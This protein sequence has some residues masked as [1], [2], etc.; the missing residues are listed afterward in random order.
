MVGPPD[1]LTS[2][3]V[4]VF[5]TAF[6]S[7]LYP[8]YLFFH[9]CVCLHAR[10]VVRVGWCV[11]LACFVVVLRRCQVRGCLGFGFASR[12]VGHWLDLEAVAAWPASSGCFMSRSV[13]TAVKLFSPS[14]GPA[15]N[16]GSPCCCSFNHRS[17][18]LL[19][20]VCIYDGSSYRGS[21]WSRPSGSSSKNLRRGRSCPQ[22][23]TTGNCIPRPPAPSCAPHPSH[24]HVGGRAG[25]WRA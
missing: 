2:V 18:Y 10:L 23:C 3:H 6:P 14:F 12:H 16:M 15:I 17:C 21:F 5:A 7:V 22:P 11:L 13:G 24:H 25:A 8:F 20:C 19:I 1:D 4:C 9:A